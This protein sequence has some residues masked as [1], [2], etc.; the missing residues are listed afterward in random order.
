MSETHTGSCLC[1]SVRFRI[2]GV[3]R[4]VVACHCTQC[5]KQSGHYYAATNAA[6]EN[7]NIEDDGSLAWYQSSNDA[8]RGFCSACGSALFWKLDSDPFTSVLAGSFD[9]P[10]GLKLS[11]HIFVSD[12]GDYYEIGDGLPQ[13]EKTS[14]SIRVSGS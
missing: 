7:L 4:E 9:K 5:R 2:T 1:G 6:D 8:K 13:H 11:R 3:L 10:T 14:S 12:K